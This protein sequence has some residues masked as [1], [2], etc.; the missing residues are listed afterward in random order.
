MNETILYLLKVSAGLGIIFIPYYFLIRNDP[1]LQLK[2]FYLLAGLVAAWVFPLIT[3]RKPELF[4]GLNPTV[5]ID[6]SGSTTGTA[7]TG[8]RPATLQGDGASASVAKNWVQLLAVVYLAGLLLL[9]ARNI[10]N[11]IKWN[12]AWK[13]SKI[14]DG[15]ALANNDQ[16]FSLFTRIFIPASL[17]DHADLNTVLLHERAHIRQLHFIDLVLMEL[18]LLL[19][20]FNPFSWLISRMIKENHEHLADRKVL[21]TGVNPARYRAQLMN[22]TLGVPVFRLGNQFNHSITFKRFNMMK[23]PK[24]SL[25]GIVKIVLLIPA[26]L[27]TLGLATG[28]SPQEKGIEG[29]VIFAG[30]EEPARGASVIIAGTTAGTVTNADGMF[31]L[32]VEGD[33]EIVISFVGY[34]TLR[35]RASEIGRKPLELEQ[36]VYTLDLENIPEKKPKKATGSISFKSSDYAEESPVFVL[37]GKVVKEIDNLDPGSIEKIEVIKKPESKLAGDLEFESESIEITNDPNDALLKKYNAENGL[38]LITTKKGSQSAPTEKESIE[39]SQEKG[40]EELFIIVEDMPSFPGGNAA[41]KDYIYSNLEYPEHAKE[42]GITGEV[43]VEFLVAASGELKDIHVVRSSYTGFDQPALDVF[44]GMPDWKPGHQHGKPVAVN[45]IVP[46][47][48]NTGKE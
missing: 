13:R 12:H 2:R 15:T 26:V 40:T 1:N 30:T 3:F 46:V 43:L 21:S 14:G 23:K 7:L 16:V 27:I 24:S 31:R 39:V 19:T 11:L 44:E 10:W 37:D 33:P 36:K 25:K 22:L 29:K 5:F 28:M 4:D 6:P 9:F 34:Q 32:N 38:I 48:F 42:Q 35:M 17:R 45:V 47:R 41:L 18:T 20:W 8:S